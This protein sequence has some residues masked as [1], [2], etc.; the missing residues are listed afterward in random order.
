MLL[1]EGAWHSRLGTAKERAEV[2]AGDAMLRLA[3]VVP[4]GKPGR[5]A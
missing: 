3:T 2:L 1:R 4:A 5:W